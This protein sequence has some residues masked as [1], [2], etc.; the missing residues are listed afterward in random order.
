MLI[1]LQITHRFK[2]PF[3]GKQDDALTLLG[4]QRHGNLSHTDKLHRVV[5]Y[6]NPGQKTINYPAARQSLQTSGRGPLR[7]WQ[8]PLKAHI[9]TASWKQQQQQKQNR[10]IPLPTPKL[11]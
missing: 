8:A 1:A 9:D 2:L 7:G 3:L 6:S 10:E 5:S 4:R 11:N